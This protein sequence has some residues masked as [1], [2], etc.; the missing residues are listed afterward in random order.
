MTEVEFFF[1]YSCPWSYLALVRLTETATRTGAPVIWKPFILEDVLARANPAA[2][3]SGADP[4]P[5]KEKYR[6]KDLQD[7]AVY[8]D[9]EIK[10][11]HGVAVDVVPALCGAVVAIDH[12]H[13]ARYSQAVFSAYFG[14]GEDISDLAKLRHL[15]ETAAIPGPEFETR[16]RDSATRERVDSN[17]AELVR[18][19]GFG[20]PTIFV[21]DAMFFG[22]D[23]MPLVEFAI[24]QASQRRFVMPGDHRA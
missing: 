11:P 14:R 9:V 16:L 17:S 5:V 12:G 1:D 21:G 7:W 18:R 20:S 24:G 23:R 3:G 8:C 10:Y 4:N 19:G 6:Q 22:N 13:A 2:P 15:A